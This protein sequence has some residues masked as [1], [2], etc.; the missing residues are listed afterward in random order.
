MTGGLVATSFSGDGSGLTSLN[1]SQ[2]TSGTLQND[3]LPAIISAP[4]QMTVGP[5]D[6]P[7]ALDYP[8]MQVTGQD[9]QNLSNPYSFRS[10][11]L[12]NVTY[13][14]SSSY[15]RRRCFQINNEY[16]PGNVE[17]NFYV[18][19]GGTVYAK[20]D[21]IVGGDIT[22]SGNISGNYLLGNGFYL[23]GI[24]TSLSGD[25]FALSNLNA[26]NLVGTIEVDSLDFEL[27]SIPANALYGELDASILT[28]TL[29]NAVLPA[30]I[31]LSTTTYTGNGL[32]VT[33]TVTVGTIS[34]SGESLTSLNAANITSGT[35]A[36]AR[37][38]TGTT[39]STGTGSVALSASPTLT[40][41]VTV[42]GSLFMNNQVANNMVCLYGDPSLSNPNSY[43]FG[44]N[45]S[46]LRYNTGANGYHWFFSNGQ[47]V[48]YF[49][50]DGS[51]VI[52]GNAYKPGGGSWNAVSDGRLKANIT[53]AN[54]DL[55]YDLVKS[56]PLQRFSYTIN[57]LEQTGLEDTRVVGWIADDVEKFFPKSVKTREAYGYDDLKTLD[58]DQLYKT[59]WGA[60][61]KLI[62]ENESL[63][64]RVEY[65]EMSM[66]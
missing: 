24:T 66:A 20:D 26:A 34:G 62:H 32:T 30:N 38:G 33:G 28:G 44:I 15:G 57:F 42:D 51:L 6:H 11:F 53:N 35:L 63:K 3:R 54:V 27:G 47:N 14:S 29:N 12:A 49:Q 40:G 1:A 50:Y 4:S 8:G 41:T 17:T 39:T 65:L 48:A 52:Y 10:M 56:L 18:N 60:V 22:V 61:T 46:M 7:Y 31:G 45:S 36:V 23:E 59:M 25:A 58:V 13:R 9:D 55:C 5:L 2:L 37:G 21:L 19:S 43:G 64:A 16:S